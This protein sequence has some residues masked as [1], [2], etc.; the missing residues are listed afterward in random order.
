LDYYGQS[1][2]WVPTLS[3]GEYLDGFKESVAKLKAIEIEYH[4]YFAARNDQQSATTHLQNVLVSV[5][6]QK[7]FLEQRIEELR[8]GLRETENEIKKYENERKGLVESLKT[9]L[10]QFETHVTSAFGLSAETFFNCLSQLGFANFSEP[11][12]LQKTLSEPGGN[13][14]VGLVERGAVLGGF[15]SAGAMVVGPLG[16]MFKEATSNIV[17]DS[18]EPVTKSWLLDQVDVI[19]ADV[20]LRSALVERRDGFKDPTVSTR[21]LVE[22]S[23]FQELC[24]KFHKSANSADLRN[25]LAVCGKSPI[26]K[27][28]HLS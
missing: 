1:P 18:G 4:K 20:D 12:R 15:A 11:A 5:G 26:F 24:K 25:S 3:L 14:K 2:R 21:L 23:K 13:L 7:D 10:T 27:S 17:T 8:S 28:S 19:G 22:L 16:L 6:A 9:K